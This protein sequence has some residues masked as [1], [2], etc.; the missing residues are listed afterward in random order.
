MNIYQRDNDVD[1]QTDMVTGT[2]GVFG[3]TTGQLKVDVNSTITISFLAMVRASEK[4]SENLLNLQP[5]FGLGFGVNTVDLGEG[6]TFTTA[7]VANG[8]TSLESDT[9]V[10]ILVSA[11]LNYKITSNLKAYG[12]YKYTESSIFSYGIIGKHSQ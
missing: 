2:A 10:G 12:E 8:S 9:I 1:Q 7:G 6:S 11:G 3:T 5:F 4:Q